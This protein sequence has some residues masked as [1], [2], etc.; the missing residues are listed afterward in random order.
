MAWSNPKTNWQGVDIPIAS[1]FN[2]IEGNINYIEEESRT[3]SDTATP[4]ASG[5]LSLILNYIVSMIKA[6]TG[7]ANW[8]DAPSKTLEDANTHINTTQNVH[9]ATSTATANS[10]IQRDASGRAKVVAPSASDDI[11]IKSTVDTVQTNLNTHTS[12]VAN[13]HGSTEYATAY[14]IIQRDGNG[15]AKIAIP[16]A[17]DDIARKDTIDTHA[18]QVAN[19]NT[20]GHVKHAVLT[21]TLDTT[22]AGTSAPYSKTVTVG[23]ILA[24]DM[25][26]ID[27]VMSGTYATDDA[28]T[29]AWGHIYRAVTSDNSITFYAKNKPTVELPIQIRVVR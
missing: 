23:G 24:T 25:P 29:K 10:I 26:I 20:V 3:P 14:R 15:R 2:R 13:V 4:A 12:S 9:G 27:V 8:W 6:I 19:I 17:S 22:W 1:D 21:A 7:K 11:A 16:V 5:K 28:R 18:A